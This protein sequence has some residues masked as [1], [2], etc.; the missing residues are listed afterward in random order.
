MKAELHDYDIF[1]KVFPAGKEIKIT[2]KPLG[3]HAEFKNPE[4]MTVK[5]FG[6][7][8]GSPNDYPERHNG[9]EVPF[10]FDGSV[11]FSFTFPT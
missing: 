10:E 7:N 9:T 4:A 6:L 11:H 8:D 2:V 1:P 3:K 5:I